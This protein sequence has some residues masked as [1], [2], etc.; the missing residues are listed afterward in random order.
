MN[1]AVLT[2]LGFLIIFAAT[3]LGAL[4]VFFFKGEISEK[5]NSAFLGL[6]SGIMVAASVWSLILPSLR[7]SE[8]YGAL[9]FVPAAAGILLGSAFLLLLDIFMPQ[10]YSKAN[11]GQK[12][13]GKG[14]KTFKLFLAI[15]VHNIPEGLAV[16]FAFGGAALVGDTSAFI[17]AFGLAVGIAVQNFPEGAAVSLPMKSA[18]QSAKNAFLFGAGSGV[19][20]PVFAV[21]GYFLSTALIAAHALF[22]SFAA[23]AMLFVVAEDMLP[24]AKSEKAPSLSARWFIFGFLIMMILDVAL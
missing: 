24:D 19:V 15:T 11:N 10:M 13:K 18:G 7:Q 8:G 6:A 16:G 5:L 21:V 12:E 1:G 22:L 20:E 2:V 23:G 4:T 9:R 3:S 14:A 17:S